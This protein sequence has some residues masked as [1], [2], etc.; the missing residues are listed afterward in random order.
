MLP[1]KD[2]QRVGTT[3]SIEKI[4]KLS[5]SWVIRVEVV[6]LMLGLVLVVVAELNLGMRLVAEFSGEIPPRPQMVYLPIGRVSRD[7]AVLIEIQGSGKEEL[8][9][10]APH[11]MKLIVLSSRY[12]IQE[13]SQTIRCLQPMMLVF[14]NPDE[15]A[16]IYLDI[17]IQQR[18]WESSRG[19]W[20]TLPEV[21]RLS[22]KVPAGMTNVLC[23]LFAFTPP[24][25]QVWELL[26]NMTE[27]GNRPF[28][29]HVAKV[30]RY[31]VTGGY[32][33]YHLDSKIL[34][35]VPPSPH[36]SLMLYHAQP[37]SMFVTA[38]IWVGSPS[39]RIVEIG[40]SLLIGSIL[41]LLLTSIPSLLT[42]QS[43]ALKD[44]D[45]TFLFHG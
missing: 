24:P 1:S 8:V 7:E 37:S 25:G 6:L 33:G 10:I 35:A 3:E 4:K 27:S 40:R 15:S 12:A 45:S 29:Y 42:S 43:S 41:L 44:T 17:S 31:N 36:W 21:K 38:R 20:F 11:A 18:V 39:F 32:I 19:G 14:E 5:R 22:I 23:W 34:Y 13:D 9:D 28:N 30:E 16:P 2:H 26:T